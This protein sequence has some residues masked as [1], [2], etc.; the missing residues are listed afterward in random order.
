MFEN[1]SFRPM[2]VSDYHWLTNIASGRGS[3]LDLL[4]IITESGN[5]THTHA[6]MQPQVL[7][8]VERASIENLQLK[9]TMQEAMELANEG[10]SVSVT[11]ETVLGWN[12][13]VTHRN[14]FLCR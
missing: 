2:F 7:K 14:S 3:T 8:V 10:Q 13:K 1:I 12:L 6:H 9:S 5:V 4:Y 11:L